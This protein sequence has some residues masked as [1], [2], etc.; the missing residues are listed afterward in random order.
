MSRLLRPLIAFQPLFIPVLLCIALWAIW[1][2]VIK[3]DYA[4]GLVLYISLVVVVDGYMNTGLF[5]PGLEKGSIHYSEVLAV[6]MLANQPALTTTWAPRKAVLWCVAIYFSLLFLTMLRTDPLLPSVFEFRRL[7]VPQILGFLVA[8]RGLGSPDDLRRFFAGLT[9]LI[10]LV[11]VFIAWDLFFD[12]LI[13][14]S[15][16]LDNPIYWFNREKNRFGSFFLNPNYLAGFIVMVFPPMFVWMLSEEQRSRSLYAL[17]AL[18]ALAFSLVQTQSRAPLLAF[19]ATMIL[20]ILGPSTS[21]SRT[22]RIGFV[23]LFAAAY[24]SISPGAITHAI[25]RFST[26]DKEETAENGRSRQTTWRYTGKMIADHPITGIGFGEAQFMRS[27]TAYGFGYEFGV[28]S[29]DAPHNSFLQATAYAGIPALLALLMANGLLVGRAFVVSLRRRKVKNGSYTF[30]LAVGITGFLACVTT[31][32]QLFSQRIAPVYWTF[33]G[34]F[35]SVVQD[36]YTLSA[37]DGQPAALA[38]LTPPGAPRPFAA[39]TMHPAPF[40]RATTHPR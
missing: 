18:M 11:A 40:S 17:V 39:A 30:G 15:D 26:L 25:Q 20:L 16:M 1:R 2:V 29:L 32:L 28:E 7:I 8:R 31:D 27:M 13:L 35:L 24:F 34:L 6:F 22:R 36:A 23:T 10:V 21:V 38:A 37:E 12:R 4:I 14:K 5:L 19:G 33:M 3:R 9:T